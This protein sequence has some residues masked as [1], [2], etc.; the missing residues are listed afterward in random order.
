[1]MR[2]AQAASNE[3]I[4]RYNAAFKPMQTHLDQMAH[5]ISAYDEDGM[6]ERPKSKFILTAVRSAFEL[7]AVV[8]GLAS[9]VAVLIVLTAMV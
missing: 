1:M 8:G 2:D 7:A 5:A 3:A 9:I 6:G 4:D